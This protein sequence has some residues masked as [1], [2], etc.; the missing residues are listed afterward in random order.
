ML[1]V[2]SH[3]IAGRSR[4]FRALVFLGA[5]GA[6]PGLF[7]ASVMVSPTTVFNDRVGPVSLTI[8]G[9]AAGQTVLVERFFDRNGNGTVDAED[10]LIFS[11]RVTDGQLPIIG[12][13]RNPNVPG[14]DDGATNG[15]IR[16]DLS[17]PGVDRVF[18]STVGRFI[19]RVSDPSSVFAP[20]SAIFE[21]QQHVLPQ[22]VSGR[23]TAAS[24]GAP[25]AGALMLLAP[26]SG[27]P[28]AAIQT[29]ANGNYS[30][31]APPG[32][33]F[34]FAIR[35]GFVSDRAAG[36]VTVAANQFATRNL[37]LASAGFVVSGRVSDSG[38]GAALAGIFIVAQST[39]NLFAGGF[40][41]AAGNYSF[42]L[43][44]DQWR[45]APADNQVAQIGYVGTSDVTATT[46]ASGALTLNFPVPR[47]TA[48]IYGNARSS[49]NPVLDLRIEAN[50]QGHLY[51]ALGYTF[52]PL[53]N[54]AVA[55]LAGT[56]SVGPD[57]DSLITRG[58]TGGSGQQVNLS[59]GQAL[60]VDFNL[61]AVTA[62]LR[63]QIKDDAGAP[64]PHIAIVVSPV[65]QNQSGADSIY[66][67]TDANGNFD[68]GV[69][70][71]TWNIALECNQAQERGYVDVS[72]FD[73]Q[74]TDGVDQNNI[75]LTFPVSTAT[76]TGF[77]RTADASAR[78]VVGVELDANQQINQ[79]SS[80]F[81]GCVTT[82]AN[83]MYTIKVLGGTW[84]VSVRGD[85]LNAR[86]FQTVADQNV[87]ISG[88]T[89]T[90][91]F[92]VTELP[93]EITSPTSASGTVG[94]PFVY[95]FQT[96]FPA[97][98]AVSNLPPGLSFNPTISA[99]TGQP[100]AAG[101]FQVMLSATNSTTTTNATLTL[102]VQNPP[103]S[104]PLITSSTSA[105]GRT[106]S[107]FTFQV[108]TS[109]ASASARLSAANLPPGLAFDP[110]TGLIS[111]T[112][113]SDGSFAVN[114][115]VT[116]GANVGM[117]TLQLTFSSDPA[118]PVI[119][120]PSSASLTPAQ[121]FSYTIVAPA[122][123][124]P[125]DP[126]VFTLIGTLP[127]GLVFNAVNGTISGTFTGF[128]NFAARGP[129]LS[130]GVITNVQ[131]FATNSAGTTT[132]PLTFFL[133]PAGVANIST[134]LSVGADP[135]V[136]IGGFIVTGNAPKRVII[137]AIAPSLSVG[138]VPVPGTLPDPTLELVGTGLS[139]TNDDWR[140]TQEQ[141]IID[142]TVAADRQPRGRHGGHA[143]P[144][145]LHRD[146]AR[147]ERRHRHRPRGSFRS[148]HRQSRHLQRRQAGQHQHPR[149]RPHGRRRHDRRFHRHR[150]H[151]SHHRARHRP[152]PDQSRRA[153]RAPGHD[154]RTRRRQRSDRFE[155]RLGE[156]TAPGNY[157]HHR[158][159]ERPPRIRRRGEPRPRQLH[160]HRP[161]QEQRNRS[162][163]GRGLCPAMREFWTNPVL[164]MFTSPPPEPRH[165]QMNT[166]TK[167][168][169]IPRHRSTPPRPISCAPAGSESAGHS[170]QLRLHRE[171]PCPQRRQLGRPRADGLHD[172]LLRL[173]QKHALREQ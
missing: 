159:A 6:A 80:Y 15:A 152:R 154:P 167:S 109:G 23:V 53:G 122:M 55:V 169:T 54:Y 144:R 102:T 44:A 45:F 104:G 95:Q 36:A 146:R 170:H 79:N 155:R 65:P 21:V 38:N 22:G 34:V 33:Y 153:R 162:R 77:V 94:L 168:L 59:A 90:A 118:L 2:P 12:G 72:G 78:P 13:V 85:D 98:L 7:A 110:I 5:I 67:E 140:A 74:V 3:S 61:D 28:I 86:G 172:Q 123:T 31:S 149:L 115:T 42:S 73:F 70:G 47:A 114:L 56:W 148:R 32:S 164:L 64:I 125:S 113:S 101:T 89:G 163:P 156:H 116:D 83:G 111:G 171:L 129:N 117:G 151:H 124:D 93:P 69:R 71:G 130:G 161:R 126:T 141:E 92:L 75:A 136:L 97:T 137:R 105:T 173:G 62:H 16:V 17:F 127:P 14:D 63:G 119:T 29:D 157:R 142:S 27:D 11:S 25:L 68:A 20:V 96:R 9:I 121:P 10:S 99:I 39:S 1:N 37:A 58:F 48:L 88:G 46:N 82:D 132:I 76:I 139:V 106:G 150:R 108:F 147:Q 24:G 128:N 131:L 100:G 84:T 40:S 60:Q 165:I 145:Q 30:L 120:S 134:R 87:T 158:T 112:P 160:R 50:D 26:A 103:A 81:P 135:N 43:T 143:Q 41:D 91:D 35:D 18:A 19:F 138:G 107:R 133:R 66:P 49:G 8:S 51:A 4:L 52:P 166:L 57:S